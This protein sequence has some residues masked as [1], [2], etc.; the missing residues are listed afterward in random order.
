MAGNVSAILTG[1]LLVLLLTGCSPPG[2]NVPRIA[3]QPPA[4]L[5]AVHYTVADALFSLLSG[6]PSFEFPMLVATF[7]S[8]DDLDQTSPLG[9]II[10]QQ[11]GSRFVQHGLNIVDVRLRTHSLLIRKDQG[12]FALSRELDKINQDV[13]AYSVLTGT[14]SV[15]Y[16]RIYITAMVLRSSDGTLLASL[17]YHLP[18]D[19]KALRQAKTV[20]ERIF[21]SPE[22]LPDPFEGIITPSVLT[23]L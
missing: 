15:V 18:V 22:Q 10:P 6:S 14:Y 23:R 3:R 20:N 11:I 21:S 16:G 13:D 4:E 12:E 2:Q 5:I 8:L 17:D 9:R 19:R 1:L 7:V